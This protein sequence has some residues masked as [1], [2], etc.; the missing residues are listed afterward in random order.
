MAV[1]TSLYLIGNE[2]L[3]QFKELIFKIT[4]EKITNIKHDPECK[5]Y[6]GCDFQIGGLNLK[7]RKAK[8]TPKKIGQFVTLWKRNDEKQIE[9]FNINDNFDFYLIAA[10][11]EDKSG[12]FVFPKN[13]LSEKQILSTNLRE[14]KRGF[15][16]YPDWVETENK[17]ARKTQLWQTKY[18]VD[19]SNTA[20]KITNYLS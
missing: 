9:P 10:E 14:G 1:N 16:V 11:Q 2:K 3:K 18:F 7:F 19:L 12:V 5:A 13:V 17:Q 15:R 8:I 20:Q 6:L 4:E